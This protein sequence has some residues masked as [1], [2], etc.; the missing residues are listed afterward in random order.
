MD[1][2][3]WPSTIPELL[4]HAAGRLLAAESSGDRGA[5]INLV[6]EHLRASL[7]VDQPLRVDDADVVCARDAAVRDGE[8]FDAFALALAASLGRQLLHQYPSSSLL[9]DAICDEL[10]DVLCT[11]DFSQLATGVWNRSADGGRT[12]VVELRE[13]PGDHADERRFTLRWGIV[14][15]TV[16]FCRHGGPHQMS[17]CAVA[18]GMGSVREPHG[19]HVFVVSIGM[20]LERLAEMPTRVVGREGFRARVHRLA[21]FCERVAERQRLAELVNGQPWRSGIGIAEKLRN[22]D[23]R[24][25]G[26]LLG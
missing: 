2:S 5:D 3:L 9:W 12:I 7:G 20:L 22:A 21:A 24:E 10:D 17:C 11:F 4:R 19:E 23:P 13:T 8:A 16:P 1:S 18:G 25:L 14:M 6:L 15:P 26:E